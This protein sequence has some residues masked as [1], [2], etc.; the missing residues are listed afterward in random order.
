MGQVGELARTQGFNDLLVG[1]TS[2]LGNFGS[3]L[4]F[5]QPPCPFLDHW[6]T[7]TVTEQ[8]FFLDCFFSQI[9]RYMI[10][11]RAMFSETLC[12]AGEQ[13]ACIDHAGEWHDCNLFIGYDSRSGTA[14]FEYP[15]HYS[16]LAECRSCAFRHWCK[17]CPAVNVRF[18]RI[19][20]VPIY[21]CHLKKRVL[22]HAAT[23]LFTDGLLAENDL[24]API[25]AAIE[26]A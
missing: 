10:Q 3:G 9:C 13:I 2:A 11:G 12:S 5:A 19:D 15:R 21:E 4:I 18:G 7:R 1:L 8:A 14:P 22:K 17:V 25:I 26:D 20:E 23:R 6:Y 16:E 24:T